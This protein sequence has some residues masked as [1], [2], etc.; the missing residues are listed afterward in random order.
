MEKKLLVTLL[1]KNIQELDMLTE[2]FQEMDTFPKALLHLASMKAN[3]ISSMLNQLA[4]SEPELPSEM[5]TQKQTARAE[6]IS[7]V[8]TTPESE[9]EDTQPTPLLDTIEQEESTHQDFTAETN[10]VDDNNQTKCEESESET[11]SEESSPLMQEALQPEFEEISTP[12]TIVEEAIVT[13]HVAKN[14]TQPAVSTRNETLAKGEPGIGEVLANKK[15]TDIKQAMSIG[16]RFRFQR[17]LFNG[18][19]EDMNK[20]IAYINLLATYAEVESFLQSKYKWET[21]NP[22]VTDFYHI[23]R[24]KF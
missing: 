17:E 18:N 12:E 13:V 3:D 19:G 7:I 20:T 21:E 22:T 10:E 6:E 24:R 15:V 11:T 23:V 1:K 5:Y 16:D 9:T 2:G 8:S 4:I 14:E